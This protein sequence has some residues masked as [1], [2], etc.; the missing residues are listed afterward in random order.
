MSKRSK[1]RMP[2]YALVGPMLTLLALT[3]CATAPSPPPASSLASLSLYQPLTL[4]L[5]EGQTIQTPQGQYTPQVDETW[6]SP[7]EYAKVVNQL[8]SAKTAIDQKKLNP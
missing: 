5:K 7:Q 4:H 6:F 1:M 8:Y 3:S 2:S